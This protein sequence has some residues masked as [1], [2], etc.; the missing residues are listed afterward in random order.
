MKKLLAAVLIGLGLMGCAT[1]SGLAPKVTTSGFDGSKRV[2]IDG[3]SVAC[4]QM[5]CPLI[6]AIWLSN[7][8][9]L[10]GLKISVINSIVSINSVDLNIDGEIIKLR[11]N[12]LT[13]F[14][15]GTL[16]E[17]SKV[18]VT[19]LTVVDKILNSKRAWIRVNTSKGLI[20]NP[21]IDGS[22]DSKAYHAL[23]RFKNQ[24]NTV[25]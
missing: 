16:L 23:K 18:F 12:T 15:T 1:T 24:V 13:D 7:N 14:S 9:N 2:F 25:K 4:D 3:H 10:V 22:K 19:D 17:S 6:G 5:V 11:E 8:P 21:I 20:E